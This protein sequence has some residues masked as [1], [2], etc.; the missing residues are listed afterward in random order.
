M[1]KLKQNAYIV[2]DV[3]PATTFLTKTEFAWEESK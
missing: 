3:L 2:Y 1:K